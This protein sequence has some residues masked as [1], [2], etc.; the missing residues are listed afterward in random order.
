MRK[1]FAAIVSL[2]V[3]GITGLIISRPARRRAVAV[4]IATAMLNLCTTLAFASPKADA[5]VPTGITTV[6]GVVTIDGLRAL[7]GQTLFSGSSIV[8]GQQSESRL[9]LGNLANLKLYGE[10]KLVMEFSGSTLSGWL[11][12]G[13]L[14]SF[15]PAGVRADIVTADAS[16]STD[17]HQLAAF[18]IQVQSGTTTVS[19]D[20]GR[21][22]IR[23]G[24]SLKSVTA[25][26]S[27]ST[28]RGESPPPQTQQNSNNRKWVWVFLGIGAAV[29]IVAIA[30]AGQDNEPPCEGGAVILSPTTGGPGICQ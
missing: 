30:I 16:I 8:T 6:G 29:A 27:F 23:A 7:S 19:V 12:K 11:E 28:A 2:E 1:Y 25:G 14:H 22:E 3:V 17:P 13:I 21:V 18:S 15:V 4:L 24:N 20:T 10:S 9:D 5:P 26:E